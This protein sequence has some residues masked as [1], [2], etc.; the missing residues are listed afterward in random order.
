MSKK[1]SFRKWHR[2]EFFYC[3]LVMTHFIIVLSFLNLVV[4]S[5]WM[6]N[7]SP[8]KICI[9]LLL[10]LSGLLI[11]HQTCVNFS[12]LYYQKK[13][14]FSPLSSSLKLN[15]FAILIGMRT[16]HLLID[17]DKWPPL[18]RTKNTIPRLF[19]VCWSIVNTPFSSI[20]KL[21]KWHMLNDFKM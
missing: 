13:K 12:P 20:S 21:L 1:K 2:K 7:I 4:V 18:Q 5:M 9:I 10:N 14:L 8:Y 11:P 16:L 19:P 6:N 3:C 15:P 17:R